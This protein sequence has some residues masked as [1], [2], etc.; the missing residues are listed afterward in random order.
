MLSNPPPIAEPTPESR[1]ALPAILPGLLIFMI[2]LLPRLL[3]LDAFVTLDEARWMGELVRFW[4]AWLA[5]DW[6]EFFSRSEAGGLLAW[7]AGL[8]W[9]GYT[10]FQPGI[11][12]PELV[13][14]LPQSRVIPL[15]LL[16]ARLPLAVLSSLS[17]SFSYGLLRARLGERTAWLAAG[18]LVLDPVIVAHTRLLSP[19][20]V[21][22]VCLLPALLLLDRAAWG[23]E[24]ALL[25]SGLLAGLAWAGHWSGWLYLLLGCGLIWPAAGRPPASRRPDWERL[26]FWLLLTVVTGLLVQ[27]WTWANP[28][29]AL[30]Q[31]GTAAPWVNPSQLLPGQTAAGFRL[32]WLHYPLYLIFYTTPLVMIGLGLLWLG[33]PARPGPGMVRMLLLFSLGGLIV[34]SGFEAAGERALL[35]VL[36]GLIIL[37]AIA[38]ADRL[39]RLVGSAG[40]AV[41][42]GLLTVQ[43][44][45]LLTVGPYYVTYLN[46]LV[47]GPWT[48]TKLIDFGRGQ[49]LDRAGAWL[50]NRPDA[51]IGR[52][53]LDL[54]YAPALAPYYSGQLFSLD[55]PDLDYAVL[56]RPSPAQLAR[57]EAEM[58][59]VHTVRL[60][61]FEYVYI[62]RRAA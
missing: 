37:A 20:G 50:N 1:F 61:G 6:A 2:A 10:R 32:G 21:M 28:W 35:P 43:W 12:F 34:R 15:F 3:W 27:P 38:W 48:A 11:S 47:G 14:A 46:P 33:R 7:L 42:L 40:R 41:G 8:G 59:L 16:W 13:A 9:W 39:S 30:L 54:D 24:T 18:L 57:F 29:H 25:G 36:A 17:L 26:I 58:V 45:L 44:L 23:S 31:A 49:G 56:Y 53:G 55:R 5:Q 60:S 22:L 19:E 4:R 51:V 52:V 62:Y